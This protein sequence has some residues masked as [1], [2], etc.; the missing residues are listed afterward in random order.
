[1]EYTTTDTFSAEKAIPSPKS[2]LVDKF[3]DLPLLIFS[4]L[5]KIALTPFIFF[6]SITSFLL[7]FVGKVLKLG[8][9]FFLTGIQ[10]V[11]RT[12]KIGAFAEKIHYAILKENGQYLKLVN[13]TLE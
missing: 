13:K 1:M 11:Q 10:G 4:W 2:G 3:L 9:T 8:L 7:S 6:L 12:L 5:L